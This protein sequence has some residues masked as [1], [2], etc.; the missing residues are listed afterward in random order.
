MSVLALRLIE[1]EITISGKSI[2]DLFEGFVHLR[3]DHAIDRN[4]PADAIDK[5]LDLDIADFLACIPDQPGKA[6]LDIW[7]RNDFMLRQLEA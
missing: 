1:P 4:M 3:Y 6:G 5:A 2:G 7:L